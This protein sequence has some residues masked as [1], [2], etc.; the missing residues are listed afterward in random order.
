MS[1][2]NKIYI[3]IQ[4]LLD[5]RQSAL[6]GLMG[7][8]EALAY[9]HKEAYYLRDLDQFPVPAQAYEELIAHDTVKAL[10]HATITYM[11]VVLTGRLSQIEKLNVFNND[12]AQ[13]E[14]V[15]NT[16][17]YTLPEGIRVA[18]RDALFVKLGTPVLITLV[19]EPLSLWTPSFIKHSG[20]SQF[21]CYN[22]GEWMQ[23][24]MPMIAGGALKEVRLFFPSLGRAALEKEGLKEIQKLG[25]RDVFGYTEFIFAPYVK[26]Q[27][28][29]T[30]FYSNLLAASAVLETFNEE[31]K[32]TPLTPEENNPKD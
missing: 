7:R 20:I 30:V 29:P 11:L 15:V 9:V 32:Q 10:S 26:I 24:H 25:F 1:E 22:G 12:N 31:L 14:L 13:I 18:F 19:N 27:F 5:V 4:S 2:N 6:V 23:M 21:Y 17:P 8:E 28:L 3:D 16:Y